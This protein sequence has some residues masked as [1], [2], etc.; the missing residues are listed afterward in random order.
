MITWGSLVG[1]LRLKDELNANK[2]NVIV[3][4]CCHV[5]TSSTN[6]LVHTWIRP[7]SLL[8]SQSLQHNRYITYVMSH[9]T[10]TFLTVYRSEKGHLFPWLS[11]FK[12][13]IPLALS[14]QSTHFLLPVTSAITWT[15]RIFSY[16]LLRQLHEPLEWHNK[17][18]ILFGV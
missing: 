8:T 17:L 11:L 12:L 13:T 5:G 1:N 7:I 2:Y 3:I 6:W 10:S 18:V 9:T 14:P 15:W 16:Q 4:V